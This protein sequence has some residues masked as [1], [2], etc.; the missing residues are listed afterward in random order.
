MYLN[1]C[2][3]FFSRKC[4]EIRNRE[5]NLDYQSLSGESNS[6]VKNFVAPPE[7]EMLALKKSDLFV[8]ITSMIILYCS[9]AIDANL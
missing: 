1:T 4:D 3:T 7:V 6:R 2:T 5:K 9:F 8:K